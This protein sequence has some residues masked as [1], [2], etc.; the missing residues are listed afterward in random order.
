M[1]GWRRPE[2]SLAFPAVML[3]N[4]TVFHVLPVLKTQIFSPGI[5][6]TLILF[7][8]VAGWAYY[9]AWENNVLDLWVAVSS[10]VLGATD[11]LPG[12]AFENQAPEH[13]PVCRFC[14]N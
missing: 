11:G 10:G 7:Y 9:G 5:I 14:G 4:G 13:F 8:P 1:V 3:V 2:F 12:C 6:T